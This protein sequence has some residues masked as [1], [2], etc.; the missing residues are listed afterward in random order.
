[1][2]EY[3]EFRAMN[4]DIVLAAEG[5]AKAASEGFAETQRFIQASEARLTRFTDTSELAQ[6]N[7]SAGT[8][9]Q[10]SAELFDVVAQ[11]SAFAEL[12]G[13]LF[14]PTILD[15]L[16][17]AGYDRSMD[18]I[19][20]RGAGPWRESRSTYQAW[21]AIGLDEQTRT[22]VLPPGVRLDLGGI[23]KG[24][25]AEQAARV[26][27]RSAVACAVNAGGDMFAIG[28]PANESAWQVGLDDPRDTQHV[29]AVLDVGPGAVVTSSTTRRRWLQGDRRQHHVIDPRS[30]APAESDWLSVTAIAAQATEAEVFAKALLIAG[31]HDGPVLA[32]I[33]PDLAFIAVDGAGTLW[34]SANARA[35]MHGVERDV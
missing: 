3:F 33:R 34:G 6:L 4:T 14:D 23:A 9:F 30:G 10:A 17:A 29:L 2:M 8:A 25:I 26:L 32:A 5:E 24:W 31:S 28:I 35:Y 22:I 1:M 18:D 16:E 13:G 27:A 15:A 7:R 11:A 21:K 20:A 12:T 19:R